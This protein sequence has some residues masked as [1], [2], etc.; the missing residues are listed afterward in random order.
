[1]F[2]TLHGGVRC[3]HWS[4]DR[5]RVSTKSETMET[6]E[7]VA[8]SARLPRRRRDGQPRH[9][10]RGPGGQRAGR[11]G[12]AQRQLQEGAAAAALRARRRQR[13]A[14]D[15]VA[16]GAHGRRLQLQPRLRGLAGRQRRAALRVRRR[17]RLAH[18]AERVA[19]RRPA[20]VARPVDVG[21]EAA[22]VHELLVPVGGQARRARHGARAAAGR[23]P[24]FAA[25]RG[26]GRAAMNE[27]TRT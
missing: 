18:H 27:P 23:V 16:L 13:R 5:V 17:G 22:D 3:I 2:T 12:L 20:H 24:L 9:A 11:A 25:R 21:D 10:E 8:V 26:G 14:R 4:A 6:G 15:A 19:Q 1:M 7:V